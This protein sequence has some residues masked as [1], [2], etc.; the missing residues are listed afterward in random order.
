[1]ERRDATLSANQPGRLFLLLL[2]S[3][4]LGPN[5][6]ALIK[7][8]SAGTTQ[9]VADRG[10][11]VFQLLA[12]PHVMA[13]LYLFFDRRDFAGVPRPAFTLLAIPIAL[14]IVN[15]IVL[16]FAP[17]PVVLVYVILTVAFTIWHFGRQNVGLVSFA[18][19][20]AGRNKR[21]KFE[22][23]TMNLGML[24]GLLGAYDAFAPQAFMLNQATWQLDL[25]AI[26]PIFS[27]FK[28]VGGA[29]FAV[30]FP[31]TVSHILVQWQR[32][33][34]LPLVLYGS[35]VF[36]FL[37]MYLSSDPLF[38]VGTWA[39]AH[40]A[41]YLVV[42]G[43][44]AAG[45]AQARSGIGVLMP[46]TLFV[47]PVVAGVLLWRFGDHLQIHGEEAEIKTAVAVLSGLTIVH[48]WVERYI[49][50]F[51]IPARRTW[52]EKSFSFLHPA[53]R[54]DRAPARRDAA[55]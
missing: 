1:V 51:S 42:L 9:F 43:F 28:Y 20:I 22:Q 4:T 35:S 13:T 41:Q 18:N 10:L 3:V 47:L 7:V 48:Y 53:I 12:A 16:A 39:F 44:H 33:D 17:M 19:R 49:W 26:D 2:V 21:N 11:W 6:L 5:L 52:M 23:M 37:P 30:L 45:R 46:V 14:L 32:R 34:A 38:A 31:M 25:S 40:G 36:F 27:R 29:I 8:S 15:G 50:R 55:T 24:A 54:H